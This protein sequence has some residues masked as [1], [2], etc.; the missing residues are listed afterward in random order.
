[1]KRLALL[2]LLLCGCSD[3][4]NKPTGWDADQEAEIIQLKD[5]VATLERE[6]RDQQ[7]TD[8]LVINE[9]GNLETH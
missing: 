4:P 3:R 8:N 5:R 7:Q 1:M 9:I 2:A 6:Q